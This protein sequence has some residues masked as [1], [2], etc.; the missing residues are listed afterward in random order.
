M[1]IIP[2]SKLP[3]H[4]FCSAAECRFDFDKVAEKLKA[5][6]MRDT[7]QDEL[8]VSNWYKGIC[9]ELSTGRYATL[10]QT[11][12]RQAIIEIGLEIRDDEFFYEEDLLEIINA[13]GID[14]DYVKR[15][16]GD[17]TWIPVNTSDSIKPPS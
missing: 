16:R 15:Y 8:P 9:L 6:P 17:F 10:S 4:D 2:L 12:M 1:K 7:F 13:L 14:G 11:E 3:K 5:E